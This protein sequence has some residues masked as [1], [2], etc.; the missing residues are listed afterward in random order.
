MGIN[1][2]GRTNWDSI[3]VPAPTPTGRQARQPPRNMED[4]VER[5]NAVGQASRATRQAFSAMANSVT[6]FDGMTAAN[7]DQYAPAQRITA[8]RV[9]YTDVRASAALIA[10][11]QQSQNQ[12]T[13]PA[14]AKPRKKPS[15]NRKVLW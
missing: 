15:H 8:Q 12:A 9:T 1:A 10:V 11:E 7:T 2:V 4:M 14:K 5:L 13:K 6:I 3:M